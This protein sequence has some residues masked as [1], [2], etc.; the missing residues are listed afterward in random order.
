V[1]FSVVPSLLRLAAEE[2]KHTVIWRETSAQHFP[3]S[4]DGS[5]EQGKKIEG[6]FIEKMYE[7]KNQRT[8][9]STIADQSGL[10]G[11][12]AASPK[13][14]TSSPSAKMSAPSS[15]LISSPSHPY[16]TY[17]CAPVSSLEAAESQNWRNLEI[18]DALA[19]YDPQGKI[20]LVP[21]FLVSLA[22]HDLHKAQ[23]GDCT[24]YCHSPLIWQPVWQAIYDVVLQR[25]QEKGS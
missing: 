8:R 19:Q 21:F 6:S 3:H 4:L 12:E 18:K 23:H 24:H 16:L 5:Y 22:R 25:E 11:N 14:M 7:N 1:Q 13:V 17:F 10:F 2:H 20:K 9:I 15:L